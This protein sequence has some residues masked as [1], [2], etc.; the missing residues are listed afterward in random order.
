VDVDETVACNVAFAL[1]QGTGVIRYR[2]LVPPLTGEETQAR[3]AE[4]ADRAKRWLEATCRANVLWNNPHTLPKKLQFRKASAP[5]DSE[6]KGDWFSFDLGGTFEGGDEHGQQ[7]LAEVKMYEDDGSSLGGMFRDFLACCYRVEDLLGPTHF[8]RYL[9]IT[10]VP[11]LGS[12]WSELQTETFVKAAIEEKDYRCAAALGGAAYDRTVGE[13]VA[14]KVIIV[15]LSSKQERFLALSDG[16]LPEV[17]KALV[18]IR[19]AS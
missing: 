7:F 14:E 9:W 18:D 3:G 4:G 13:R 8:D 16:E 11:F 12:K 17:L 1:S 5:E 19:R 10:W 2:L 15:I 6:A